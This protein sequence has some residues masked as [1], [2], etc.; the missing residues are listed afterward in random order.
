MKIT[1]PT[2]QFSDQEIAHIKLIKGTVWKLFEENIYNVALGTGLP[3]WP[4][5]NAGLQDI[6]LAGGMFVSLFQGHS[7]K[8]YD[9]YILNNN[10]ELYDYLKGLLMPGLE[11]PE[12]DELEHTTVILPGPLKLKQLKSKPYNYNPRIL[13]VCGGDEKL[14]ALAQRGESYKFQLVLTDYTSRKEVLDDFDFVHC[15][16]SMDF[17]AMLGNENSNL[18]I[19]RNMYDAILKKHLILS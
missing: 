14:A 7:P 2:L 9:L 6:V 8:D 18:Y 5:L 12:V 17:K 15:K 19:T 4:I 11:P 1:S 10:R 3:K 13:S 16:V